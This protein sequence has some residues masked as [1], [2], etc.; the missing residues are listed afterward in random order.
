MQS[1][2]G[3]WA[4]LCC[5][6]AWAA[7]AAGGG[8]VIVFDVTGTSRAV[9]TTMTSAKGVANRAE[10][11]LF[12]RN[13]AAGLNDP[14][15]WLDLYLS[16]RPELVAVQS[17]SV[18]ATLGFLRSQGLLA[19][20]VR[21]DESTRNEAVSV[22]GVL[23]AVAA[24][25]TFTESQ[26]Q[27]AGLTMLADVRGRDSAWVWATYGPL[28][29]RDRIFVSDDERG[30]RGLELNDLVT[31][32]R[33][34]MTFQNWT[35]YLPGQTDHGSVYGWA[36]EFQLFSTASTN[37]L[38][39]GAADFLMA[40]SATSRFEMDVPAQEGFDP[41]TPAADGVHYL[42][43]VMSDGD[44]VAWQTND[45]SWGT[46][47]YGSADR[48]TFDM[49]WDTNPV[50]AELNPAMLTSVYDSASRGEHRDYFIA[51]GGRNLVYPSRV[52]DIEGFMDVTMP[53]MASAD[54]SI[55]S[56]LDPSYDLS[57][58]EAMVAREGILGLMFKTNSG[59][60]KERNGAL[61]WFEGK[62]ILSVRYSLWQGFDH[63]HEIATAAAG[64]PRDPRRDASSYTIV[65]VHPW[66]QIDGLGAMTNARVTADL[67]PASVEVVA[68]DEL[69]VHLR[70][71]H[72]APVFGPQTRYADNFELTGATGSPPGWFRS[73]GAFVERQSAYNGRVA[74]GF[75]GDGQ[76]WRSED[77][78]GQPGATMELTLASRVMPPTG[79]GPAGSALAQLRCFAEDGSFLGE[80]S[81]PLG[82]SA[83]WTRR[84]G[85]FTL[86]AGAA[87]LDIRISSKFT[88][89]A[90]TALVD[91]IR[92]EQIATPCPADFNGDG[93]A[94][95][96]D[97]LDFLDAL[98]A[99]WPEADFNDDGVIDFF[100]ARGFL[101]ALGGGC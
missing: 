64:L 90:G 35:S 82:A 76:D 83:D 94:D 48:G 26:A 73:S 46:R 84:S 49:T 6:V 86:P 23:D 59:A 85:E 34:F 75:S 71:N 78:A 61:D 20:Y 53:A 70:N 56:V 8:P 98:D 5:L 44:N 63:P 62:P 36:D 50:L 93:A 69:M 65:N 54:L 29:S 4:A 2:M 11:R 39:T 74:I 79:G 13:G 55:I 51:A 43:F 97:V 68:L 100:D 99:S 33:G 9:A 42:A 101:G 91:D 16:R 41:T 38:S 15:R 24:T 66:S 37:N 3:A 80:L 96:L 10:L 57:K 92:V 27:Q 14:G 7:P 88:A 12:V 67:L 89:L 32:S 1:V 52:P 30:F 45:F 19:G 18:S 47:W 77:F 95:E 40:S 25:D 28:F 87:T 58:L 81:L 60:Y 31:A 17:Q 72:G 21:G 22:A